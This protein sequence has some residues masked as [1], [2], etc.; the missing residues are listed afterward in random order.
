MNFSADNHRPICST[1]S[2]SAVA[3]NDPE[4]EIHHTLIYTGAKSLSFETALLRSTKVTKTKLVQS[5]MERVLTAFPIQQAKDKTAESAPR[6][7]PD[8]AD[9]KPE[10]LSKYVVQPA[11]IAT[12]SNFEHIL[13]H[14]SVVTEADVERFAENILDRLARLIKSEIVKTAEA[15]FEEGFQSSHFDSRN[16]LKTMIYHIVEHVLPEVVRSC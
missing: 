16:G 2:H 12:K 14:L 13:A 4:C 11:I 3:L 1:M 8:D 7:D 6:T 10:P 15:T 5:F 9:R